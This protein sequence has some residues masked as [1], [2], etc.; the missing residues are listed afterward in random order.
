MSRLSLS[1]DERGIL[2]FKFWP[3]LGYRRLMQISFG[4]MTLGFVVQWLTGLA[5][6]GVL[7]LLAGN[8]LLLV[9]GYHN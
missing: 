4:L 9:T 6:P 1:N 3:N 5:F 8:V 2:V 7:V